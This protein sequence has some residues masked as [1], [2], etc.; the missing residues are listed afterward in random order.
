MKLEDKIISLEL[1]KKIGKV[2]KEKGVG[3]DFAAYSY[4]IVSK[5]GGIAET[6]TL[7]ANRTAQMPQRPRLIRLSWGGS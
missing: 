5:L 4:K 1:A 7:L 6:Q 3:L 2:A